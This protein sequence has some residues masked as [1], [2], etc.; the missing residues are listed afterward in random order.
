MAKREVLLS[1]SSGKDSAWTLHALR[2]SPDIRVSGFLTTINEAFD[3]VAMH[4][5]RRE[6]LEEQAAAAGV[7]LWPIIIPYP[8]SNEQ[9]EEAMTRVLGKARRAGISG[10]R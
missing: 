2:E 4:A 9:Y 3:R 7:E 1:W 10:F 5:V 6:L 8:C